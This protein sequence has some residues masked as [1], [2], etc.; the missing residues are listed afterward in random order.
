VKR[1]IIWL[2]LIIIIYSFVLEVLALAKSDKII[3]I[4]GG[5]V[6]RVFQK[7]KFYNFSGGQRTNIQDC[8]SVYI[9]NFT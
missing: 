6:T 5:R 8:H 3:I 4:H 2:L 9:Y 7:C 1:G